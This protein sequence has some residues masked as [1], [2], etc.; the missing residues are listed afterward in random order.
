MFKIWFNIQR[1]YYSFKGFN[2]KGK[3]GW[4]RCRPY[5]VVDSK[6]Y[7]YAQAYTLPEFSFKKLEADPEV[8]KYMD[9]IEKI[10][11]KMLPEEKLTKMAEEIQYFI[12]T[13]EPYCVDAEGN[14]TGLYEKTKMQR[15]KSWL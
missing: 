6:G 5:I 7:K 2:Y 11:N 15:I 12:L 14:V 3:S 4:Y 8:K 9:K 1:L 13:G 10:F